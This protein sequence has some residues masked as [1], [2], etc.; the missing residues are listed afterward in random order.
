MCFRSFTLP[1]LD[2]SDGNNV[3]FTPR[4]L[5]DEQFQINNP[6]C[7]QYI[8]V[9]VLFMDEDEALLIHPAVYTLTLMHQ[10]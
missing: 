5:S 4:H 3:L 1:L 10:Q 9:D 6:K 7:N 8:H 2:C